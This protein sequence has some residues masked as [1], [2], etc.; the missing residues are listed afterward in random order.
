[1]DQQI[2]ILLFIAISYLE[3]IKHVMIQ[4]VRDWTGNNFGPMAVRYA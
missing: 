1:M 3:S 4:L 2:I